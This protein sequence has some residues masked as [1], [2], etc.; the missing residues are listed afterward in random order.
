[1]LPAVFDVARLAPFDVRYNVLRLP[2]REGDSSGGGLHFTVASTA[3]PNSSGRLDPSDDL[4][5]VK[6]SLLYAGTG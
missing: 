6:A 1:L 3:R 5:L 2:D 4:A